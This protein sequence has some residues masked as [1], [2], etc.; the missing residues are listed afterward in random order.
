MA[1][2]RTLIEKLRAGGQ[3]TV[4]DLES[5]GVKKKDPEARPAKVCSPKRAVEKAKKGIILNRWELEDLAKN[6]EQAVEYAKLKNKRFPECEENLVAKGSRRMIVEYFLD[7][8]EEPSELFEKWLIAGEQGLIKRY[9]SEV[10]KSRWAE[11]EESLLKVAHRWNGELDAS[12]ALAYQKEFRLGPWEQLERLLLN[13]KAKVGDRAGSVRE[14]L[15][16]CG[17]GRH[18]VTERRLLK[19]GNTS[20]IFF[21]ARYCVGGRL[22]DELHNKMVLSGKKSAKRY[23]SWLSSRKR[24]VLNYLL[25]VGEDERREMMGM[26]PEDSG[27]TG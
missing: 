22:P 19:F 5:L 27:R 20:A 13:G 21:Y 17:P 10:R 9:C 24:S 4:E 7:L 2:K 11:G 18:E 23:L 3:I 14:Y 1:T 25:S 12:H 8:V 26:F 6:P 15:K 16:N